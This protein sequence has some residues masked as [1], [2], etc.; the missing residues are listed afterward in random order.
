MQSRGLDRCCAVVRG[1]GTVRYRVAG[2]RLG[3]AP[4]REGEATKRTVWTGIG[5]ER[6]GVD[7]QGRSREGCGDGRV[8]LRDVVVWMREVRSR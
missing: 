2:E 7:V 8:S 1:K 6:C 4:C 3:Q 5:K